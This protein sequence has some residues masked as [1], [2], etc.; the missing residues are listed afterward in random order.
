ML[1]ADMGGFVLRYTA[2]DSQADNGIVQHADQSQHAL[3]PASDHSTQCIIPHSTEALER[4]NKL[5]VSKGL[6]IWHLTCGSLRGVIENGHLSPEI[7]PAEEILDKS[8]SDM[9]TKILIIVQVSYFVVAVVARAIKRLPITQLELGVCAFVAC[10]AFTYGFT[11]SK[12]KSVTTAIAVHDY[13]AGSLPPSLLEMLRKTQHYQR[14]PGAAPSNEETSPHEY[15][16]AW[17]MVVST[18]IVF[19]GI[20]LAGWNFHFPSAADAWLWRSASIISIVVPAISF[21]ADVIT[22]DLDEIMAGFVLLYSL[23]RLIL[24]VEMFR[25]MAYLTPQDFMTTWTTN[26]PHIG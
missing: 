18:A 14:R 19:G 24:I 22:H 1:F 9:F 4:N 21:L 7:V 23:V 16:I 15:K 5:N 10:S 8:K 3:D 13:G 12:P 11:L 26:I 17:R 20:H 6:S 25:C 2:K